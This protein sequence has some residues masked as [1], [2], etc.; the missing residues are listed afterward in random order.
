[1]IPELVPR[2]NDLLDEQRISDSLADEEERGRE[3]ILRKAVQHSR[4][5]FRMRAIVEGE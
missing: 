1:V 3:F 2:V 5:V 4:S